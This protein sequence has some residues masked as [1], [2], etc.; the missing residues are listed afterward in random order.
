MTYIEYILFHLLYTLSQICYRNS[1][2]ITIVIHSAI[3]SHQPLLT[4][5]VYFVGTIVPILEPPQVAVL[6]S[7]IQEILTRIAPPDSIELSCKTN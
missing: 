2:R 6:H 7:I 4:A 5:I 3:L 1:F